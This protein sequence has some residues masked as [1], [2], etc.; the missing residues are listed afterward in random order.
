MDVDIYATMLRR[1]AEV[2]RGSAQ[3]ARRLCHLAGTW[4]ACFVPDTPSLIAATI[5]T[6]AEERAS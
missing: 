4:Q 3:L 1:V 6:P 2:D 5:T